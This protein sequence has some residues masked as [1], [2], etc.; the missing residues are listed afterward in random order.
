LA[1]P[2]GP[3][4]ARALRQATTEALT[5]LVTQSNLNIAQTRK[6]LPI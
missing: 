6:Y 3:V 2:H 4:A 5:N 1:I